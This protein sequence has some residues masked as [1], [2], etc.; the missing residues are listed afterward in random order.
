MKMKFL[1]KDNEVYIK[2][3]DIVQYLVKCTDAFIKDDNAK[4]VI[5][6]KLLVKLAAVFGDI[7]R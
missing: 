4:T 3:S 5:A 1:E 6:K 7:G 2:R